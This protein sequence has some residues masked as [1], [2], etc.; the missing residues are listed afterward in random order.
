MSLEGD[1]IFAHYDI[2]AS[3]YN[4]GA[5]TLTNEY[6]T[7][8]ISINTDKRLVANAYFSRR[9]SKNSLSDKSGSSDLMKSVDLQIDALFDKKEWASNGNG[10]AQVDYL[11]NSYC[12]SRKLYKLYSKQFKNALKASYK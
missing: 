2:A 10:G 4:S 5:Y 8:V 6:Y 3:H 11:Y 1:D 7:N 9:K 12:V